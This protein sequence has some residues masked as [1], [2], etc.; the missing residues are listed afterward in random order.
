MSSNKYQ[1]ETPN[2]KQYIYLIRDYR[3]HQ[4]TPTNYIKIPLNTENIEI[5][6]VHTQKKKKRKKVDIL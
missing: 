1:K 4:R 6:E 5:V 3:K 2:E